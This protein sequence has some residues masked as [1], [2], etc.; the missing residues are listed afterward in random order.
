VCVRPREREQKEVSV[1]LNRL[2]TTQ[3]A[4]LRLSIS[5]YYFMVAESGSTN[6]PS[7]IAAPTS[8]IASK[9][10]VVFLGDAFVGKTCLINKF[11]YD[12]F[13][14]SYQVPEL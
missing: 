13:E 8:S 7:S 5:D 14:P 9:Y 3:R 1:G 6:V 2:G 11:I 10:K 4:S 12:S